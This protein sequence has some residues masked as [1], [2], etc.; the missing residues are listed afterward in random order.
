LGAAAGLPPTLGFAGL[1]LLLGATTAAHAPLATVALPI[2]ALLIT[3]AQLRQD[4]PVTDRADPAA[5]LLAGGLLAGGIVPALL[6][7]G[8]L[9]PALNTLAAGLPALAEVQDW[10]GIGLVVSQQDAVAA[11]WPAL[12]LAAT[13]VLALAAVEAAARLL[14]L[15]PRPATDLSPHPSPARG[16]ESPDLVAEPILPEAAIWAGWI[17]PGRGVRLLWERQTRGR[18]A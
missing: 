3:L 17:D 9:R 16:G 6:L 13:L 12:G 5:W 7:D 4:R 2:T 11:L 8:V 10:P 18:R 15:A 14:D 1:W